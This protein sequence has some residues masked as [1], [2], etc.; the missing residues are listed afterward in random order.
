M[1]RRSMWLLVVSAVFMA[2]VLLSGCI[3]AAD[4]INPAAIAAVGLDPTSIN[5][6]AGTVLVVFVNDSDQPVNSGSLLPID[7][8]FK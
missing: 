8:R 5:R 4:L 3:F 6:P 1:D 2:P 7:A